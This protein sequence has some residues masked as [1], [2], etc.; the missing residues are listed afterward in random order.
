MKDDG[1]GFYSYSAVFTSVCPPSPSG[2]NAIC[3]CKI[4]P[5]RFPR[6]SAPLF[7]VCAA[8]VIGGVAAATPGVDVA[9]AVASDGIIVL[10]RSNGNYT[11]LVIS[12]FRGRV[13]DVVSSLLMNN[14]RDERFPCSHVLSP[15]FRIG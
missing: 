9:V 12:T 1:N 13:Y 10:T 7:A 11:V 5:Y 2:I 8:V 15:L 3:A 4:A 6:L 14:E